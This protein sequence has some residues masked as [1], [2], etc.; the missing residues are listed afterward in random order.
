MAACCSTGWSMRWRRDPG[1]IRMAPCFSSTSTTSRT[2]T[3]RWDMIWATCCCS[4]LPGASG[5]RRARSIPWHDWGD[6]FVL[7]AEGLASK[8]GEAMHQ[9]ELVAEKVIGLL[10]EPYLLP[11]REY[12]GG[13]SIGVT[14]FSD[15][16]DTVEELLKRADL[17]MYKAKSAGRNRVRFFNPQMQEEV[18]ARANL[19]ADMR[20]GLRERQ[21]YV[22]FQP[23]VD[24]S[25]NVTGAE[26][27]V[28]W[29]HPKKGVISP[30]D[31]I[32]VAE[33]TGLILPLGRWILESACQQL[34]AW[35]RDPRLGRLKLAVNIS[36]SQFHH[37]EFVRDVIEVLADTGAD[38]RLLELEL[39][40]SQLVEDA[41]AMIVNMNRL[42]DQGVRFSLDDFGTGYSSLSYLK[43]LPLDHLKIDQSF[44]RDLLVD[45]NDAA[46]VRTVIA[47]GRSLDLEVIAEGVENDAQWQSLQALGC[48]LYQ[49]YLFSRP[50]AVEVLQQLCRQRGSD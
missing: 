45:P 7:M 1:I 13:A 49:G 27:L 35:S 26:V 43:R 41:E 2:L 39:T 15:G 4:R 29:R 24:A 19:E 12:S 9:A 5:S 21:F 47:L 31:F 3:I 23:V 44:V 25:G 34:V 40:E 33:A 14:L 6:E 32:P 17:A 30:A 18:T 38:P 28:R 48:D 11:G 22:E 20:R 50:V 16:D 37:P 36:A 8:P 10:A 42:R 46:I